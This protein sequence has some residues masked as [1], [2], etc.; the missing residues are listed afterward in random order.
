MKF[1][2]GAYSSQRRYGDDDTNFKSGFTNLGEFYDRTLGPLLN[3]TLPE[4]MPVCYR[5]NFA[6]SVFNIRKVPWKVWEALEMSL[7]RGNNI[8]EGHFMERLW[9]ILLATPLQPYQIAAL[10][11]HS[12]QNV[13]NLSEIGIA[14]VLGLRNPSPMT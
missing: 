14:G 8:E 3:T 12:G 1:S 11:N 9:G 4:L 13:I 7:S 2:I 5:G 10:W 6:A